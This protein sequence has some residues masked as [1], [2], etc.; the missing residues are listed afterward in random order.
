M[1]AGNSPRSQQAPHSA[2]LIDP[3]RGDVEDDAASTKQ[4]SLLA[5]AGTLVAE[6]SLPKLI[7]ACTASILLPSVLLGLGPLIVTAWLATVSEK[8]ATLTEISAV[9]V[10]LGALLLAWIGGRPLMRIVEANFWSLNAMAVQPGYALCREAV[11]HVAERRLEKRSDASARARLRARSAAV[12]GVLLCGCAFTIVLI[13]WPRSR[14]T[15]VA[16]DLFLL[17]RLL[18]PALANAVIVVAAYLG[19]VSLIWGVADASMDQPIN[20]ASFDAAPMGARTWRIAH[21]SDMHVVGERYGYRIESGRS[22][23][24]GNDRFLRCMTRLEAIHAERELDIILVSGDMTDAG[25]S[26]EWAEFLDAVGGHPRLARRMLIIPGN[27]DV[28]VVDRSNPARLDLPF[29]PGKRLRQLRAIS[30][31]A[32]VQGDRVRIFDHATGGLR[33][34]LAELLAPH[35]DLIAAFADKGTL[36]L[37]A[38][39]R[40]LWNDLFPMILPPDGEDGLGVLML[41]SNVEAH[42]SFT[43]ALGMVSVEQARCIKAAARR[44][45]RARWLVALHHHLVEYPMPVT[46]FSERIGTALINGTWFIRQL[47]PLAGRLLIMHGHRHIDWMGACGGVKI[48]SA[49]SPVMAAGDQPTHFYVHALAAGE[50]GELGLLPPERI[51]LL[52]LDASAEPS[53]SL[54]VVG[55]DPAKP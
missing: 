42:F 24:R 5:I 48:L 9:I 28:N 20:L 25:R 49:P 52:P 15:G 4:R 34:T 29:S 10:L 13:V 23:P 33:G 51:D 35:R 44:F 16:S 11:C 7:V 2:A 43:N 3:R 26:A 27:H 21:L 12:S 32:Q 40:H 36:R 45:S 6:I 1:R 30:A 17:H 41:N 47:R 39:L 38:R 46:A 55:K 19:T 37:A 50:R 31:M 54:S 18:V 8:M 14:W 53:Q 22:G